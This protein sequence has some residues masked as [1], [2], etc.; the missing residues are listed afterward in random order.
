MET[1]IESAITEQQK[2]MEMRLKMMDEVLRKQTENGEEL[3]KEILQ[4]KEEAAEKQ[5]L[6]E[7]EMNRV[8]SDI[9]KLCEKQEENQRRIGKAMQETASITE[10]RRAEGV[11]TMMNVLLGMA[12]DIKRNGE[13]AD[14]TTRGVDKMLTRVEKLERNDMVTNSMQASISDHLRQTD[15]RYKMPEHL[16]TM[17]DDGEGMET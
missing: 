8:M 9:S 10:Q 2:R 11:N 3:K 5:G 17:S 4:M 13:K 1:K 12:A 7:T 14:A 16:E 6:H 15:L